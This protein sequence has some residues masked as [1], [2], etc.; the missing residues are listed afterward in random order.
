M[1]NVGYSYPKIRM[2]EKVEHNI[3]KEIL[4]ML[5]SMNSINRIKLFHK[6]QDKL[7]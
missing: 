1:E 4:N 5:S 3:R 6:S 2:T 7:N